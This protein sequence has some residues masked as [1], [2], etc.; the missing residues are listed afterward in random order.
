MNDTDKLIADIYE[1]A[2]MPH[3]WER[4]LTEIAEFAGCKTGLLFTSNDIGTAYVCTENFADIFRE[5]IDKDWFSKTDRTNRLIR[6]RHSGFVTDF[7]VFSYDEFQSEP[8]FYSFF[9]KIGLHS[10]VATS[11]EMPTSTNIV[12]DFENEY[13]T[14]PVT[15]DAVAK[16]DLLRPHL[17]RAALLSARLELK[18][19]R[20]M[21]DALDRVAIP[22]IAVGHAGQPLAVND[23]C[24]A[25][26]GAVVRTDRKVSIVHRSADLL[27]QDA[28]TSVSREADSTTRS[29]AIPAGDQNSAFVAHVIPIRRTARDIFSATS[30]LIMFS[31]F[32][33]R[34]PL[35]IELVMSLFDLTHTE[36][37]V[38]RSVASGKTVEEI[39]RAFGTQEATVR[40]QLKKV[41]QKTGT[42]RQLEL[43]RLIT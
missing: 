10:G 9:H 2:A 16:L 33:G 39:A 26:I 42:G 12:F 40:S 21:V 6:K 23:A 35:S 38:A 41:L 7:D 25:L 14:G 22:A 28:L 4:V 32:S 43:A 19:A 1:A 24:E 3:E 37:R 27:L 18:A 15:P 34:E 36:A 13:H 29:I 17:C 31:E 30:A 11:V 5:Y 8:L 20:T